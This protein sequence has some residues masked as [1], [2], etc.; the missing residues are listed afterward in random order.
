MNTYE[1]KLEAKRARYQ[2]L[3]EKKEAEAR[4]RYK[5]VDDIAKMIPMGQPVLVGHHSEKRHRKDLERMDQNMRKGIEASDA[6]KYYKNKAETYGTYSISADDPDAVR[7]LKQEL[8]ELEH[9]QAVMKNVNKI[10]RNKK[11]T[12]EE[13]IEQLKALHASAHEIRSWLTPDYMGKC[14][15]PSYVLS[16]RSANIRR[17]KQRIDQLSATQMQEPQEDTEHPDYRVVL[18]TEDNRVRIFFTGIPAAPVR[19]Y[20]KSHGWKWA[21]S[22]QA[23]QRYAHTNGMRHAKEFQA[24]YSSQTS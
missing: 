4:A 22:V 3:A 1:K 17:I 15:V 11:L 8:Q 19:K 24:W 10:I 9:D 6:A 7:K 5:A 16:N 2:E 20:L 23:W 21:P 13:K 14:G 12:K 18:N